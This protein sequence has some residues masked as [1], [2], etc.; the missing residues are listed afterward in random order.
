MSVQ[1]IAVRIAA[2]Y[3]HPV[4]G[5]SPE[6]MNEALLEEN[7]HFPHDRLFAIENGP[8]GFDPAA[9]AHQP[10]FKFLMLMRNARLARLTT[11]Y[12]EA[13]GLLTI[14]QDGAV[15]AQG[16]LHEED[17]RNAITAFLESYLNDEMRGP[18]KLLSAPGYRF[19]DSKSG[20]LSILNLASVADIAAK[21]GRPV[22]DP[23]R[24]RANIHV[25][26]WA[27]WAENTLVGARLAV[28]EVELEVIKRI[29]RC[30]AT[31]VDP[32]T[33]IRDLRMIEAL[34]RL[35]QHHDCGIY[36]KITRRGMIRPGDEIRVV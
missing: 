34:E 31:D 8:S 15:Q 14:A 1:K 32:R 12:N 30:A 35:Y 23:L 36:A 6:A 20:F 24:F 28:G 10:K 17:G 4:K 25:K 9:P 33:G 2:L 21:I 3:R 13:S 18:A 29:E 11:R 27:P 16:H 19:M 26:G 7:G 22:L 5:L